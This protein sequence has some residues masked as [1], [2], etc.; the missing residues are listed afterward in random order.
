[1]IVFG[2]I[3][4]S[5]DQ[6]R[7]AISVRVSYFAQS[8]DIHLYNISIRTLHTQLI[9]AR[10]HIKTSV[11]FTSRCLL[12]NIYHLYETGKIVLIEKQLLRVALSLSF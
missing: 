2:C 7:D 8:Y 4:A 5:D 1:M 12:Y 6:N 3:F 9:H 11:S 10:R